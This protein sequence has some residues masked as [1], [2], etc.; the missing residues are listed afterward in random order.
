MNGALVYLT[1]RTVR[2]RLR[3]RASQLRRPRYLIAFALGILYV[4][5][6]FGGERPRP[7]PETAIVAQS[8]ELLGAIMLVGVAAWSWTFGSERRALGFSPAEVT[9]LFPAPLTRRA[10]LH[11]KMARL[12]LVILI[13]V[14][15]WTL[16][17][18]RQAGIAGWQR[19][20]ALW[21]LLSTI[22]LHRTAA[23]LVRRSLVEHGAAALRRRV[24]SLTLAAVA[25]A[26][27]VSGLI[28]ALPS[29]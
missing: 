24:V 20:V 9:L 10:L 26:G 6:L 13:N 5:G 4:V 14:A 16:L 15:I 17:L 1:V 19:A 2:N 25:I 21:V 18:S 29:L 3:Y 8:A 11:Y 22:A 7:L 28:A 23:A 27:V 12:Q